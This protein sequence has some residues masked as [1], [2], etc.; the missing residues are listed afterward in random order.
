MTTG[1]IAEVV[2]LRVTLHHALRDGKRLVR[3]PRPGSARRAYSEGKV[4]VTL[5]VTL[6]HAERDGKRLVRDPRPGSARRTYCP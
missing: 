4:V 1:A 3:D 6:R 2:T 5:R